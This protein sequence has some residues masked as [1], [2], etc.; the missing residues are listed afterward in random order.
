MSRPL[1]GPGVDAREIEA[2]LRLRMLDGVGD[3]RLRML[4][5]RYGSARQALRRAGPG[6]L[7]TAAAAGRES[8]KLRERAR[9]GASWLRE[10]GA[11]VVLESDPL[12][13]ARLRHLSQ[14]PALLYALGRL[15][16]LRA[17]AV[18]VVGARRCTEYGADVARSLAA[19][20]ARSGLVVVSGL[21]RG[22]DVQAHLGA[23]ESGSTIAVL[24][25]GL[26]VTYPHGH[27]RVQRRI[28]RDGL[29]LTEFEP[30]TP[31]LP[32]NF[33]R[34]NRLIAAL[35]LGVLVVEAGHRSG[36]LSTVKRATELGRDIMAVPGP[37][38]RE[39]S[40]GTNALL[41]D[42]ARLVAGPTDVLDELGLAPAAVARGSGTAHP[43]GAGGAA[44]SGAAGGATPEMSDGPDRGLPTLLGRE[45]RHVDELAAAAGVPPGRAL[46][47]L[48][49]LEL[50]GLARQ[51]PG[52]R[53]VLG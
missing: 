48:L 31:G 5:A 16:L 2:L 13:P 3:A 8:G 39:T 7:G 23:L 1:A 29:L 22:I 15:D 32:H 40:E 4:L 25:T 41:R 46:A 53:F 38:G 30:G 45:P 21:A 24:G 43:V 14:P 9:R 36:A 34:R 33:P 10:A 37:I 42:G 47:T 19:G 51:L 44:N 6:E 28:A 17:P 35:A 27:E 20:V 18:A 12:Y 49:E 52:M 11:R 26:D 50:Q